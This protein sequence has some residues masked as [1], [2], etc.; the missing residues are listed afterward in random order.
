MGA[1]RDELW[2]VGHTAQLVEGGNSGP[3]WL[4]APASHHEDGSAPDHLLIDSDD[5]ETVARSLVVLLAATIGDEQMLALLGR[6]TS[7]T[8][9]D[10]RRLIGQPWMIS[11]DVAVD[12][13]RMLADSLRLGIVQLSD[14]SVLNDAVFAHLRTWGF[15]VDIYAPS[16]G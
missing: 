3:V 15:R 1:F 2:R 11:N 13:S 9:G 10:G 7:I 8:I 5:P 6:S 14:V 16:A 12:L 4:T